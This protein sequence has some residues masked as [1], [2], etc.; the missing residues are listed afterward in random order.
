MGSLLV[1]PLEQL[2]GSLIRQGVTRMGEPSD[3]IVVG[4]GL[5]GQADRLLERVVGA[6][7]ESPQERLDLGERL[8]D[9]REVGRVGRQEE[10]VAAARRDVAAP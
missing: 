8:L 9:R 4:T 2:S 3:G 6:C 7:T 1:R 10:Q 5:D